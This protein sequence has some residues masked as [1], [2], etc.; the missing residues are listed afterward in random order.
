MAYVNNKW[1]LV[2][3]V[4]NPGENTSIPDKE[5]TKCLSLDSNKSSTILPLGH[6]L[7]ITVPGC[8]SGQPLKARVRANKYCIYTHVSR[9]I[10]QLWEWQRE[11]IWADDWKVPPPDVIYL[12]YRNSSHAMPMHGFTSSR[13]SYIFWSCSYFPLNN[14]AQNESKMEGWEG[15]DCWK[16]THMSATFLLSIPGVIAIQGAGVGGRGWGQQQH[17]PNTKSILNISDMRV[18]GLVWSSWLWT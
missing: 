3:F 11:H 9:R 16:K 10:S 18:A 17:I 15:T 14:H 13:I 7:V 4:F 1:F 6:C 8:D 12:N 2:I 5:M